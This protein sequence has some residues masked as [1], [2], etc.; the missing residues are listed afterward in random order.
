M[1]YKGS[2]RRGLTVPDIHKSND[3]ESVTPSFCSSLVFSSQVTDL[4]QT[5]YAALREGS[6]FEL[7]NLVC[8][9]NVRIDFKTASLQSVHGVQA[10]LRLLIGRWV[11][12]IRAN[13]AVRVLEGATPVASFVRLGSAVHRLASH[14]ATL[15]VN[16]Q[17]CSS[18]ALAASFTGDLYVSRTFP[19]TGQ[20]LPV[21][22]TISASASVCRS[23]RSR[24]GKRQSWLGGCCT[25]VHV[26]C[27][28]LSLW[29]RWGW[30]HGLPAVPQACWVSR[31]S[32]RLPSLSPEKATC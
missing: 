13:Q 17:V 5:D 25:A 10:L 24:S 9:N 20:K 4:L 27:C 23:P 12:D 15:P 18:P 2:K 30:V 16:S 22:A 6:L 32:P 26:T 11:A 8:W 31:C 29:R 28:T 7:V 1:L 14:A 3:F 19:S 21:A